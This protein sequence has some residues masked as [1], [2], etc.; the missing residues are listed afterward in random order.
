M[1]SS[2]IFGIKSLLDKYSQEEQ[3]SS[4]EDYLDNG[5]EIE[6]EYNYNGTITENE[7]QVLE[8]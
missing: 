7:L 8:E 5:W 6:A 4:V 3:K 1:L 2:I